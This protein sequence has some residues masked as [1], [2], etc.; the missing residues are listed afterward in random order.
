MT[1]EVWKG[2]F[3]VADVAE[4][5]AVDGI[6]LVLSGQQGSSE[7]RVQIELESCR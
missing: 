2:V 1:L 4:G 6:G 5:W 7:C 3:A